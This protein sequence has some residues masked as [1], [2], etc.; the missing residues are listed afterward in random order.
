MDH[1]RILR[2]FFSLFLGSWLVVACSG[3][4]SSMDQKDLKNALMRER[5]MLADMYADDY[6]PPHLVDQC[7]AVL[8]GMCHRIETEDPKDLEGLYAI[9]HEA[10]ERLNA[11]QAVFEEHGSELETGARE[12]LGEEFMM[13]AEAYGFDADVEE[14]IA[15]REW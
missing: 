2:L 1:L 9:T 14:M 6:F 10:T 13:I 12:A 4:P 5:N 11:L 8:V 3:V 15:P 7:K